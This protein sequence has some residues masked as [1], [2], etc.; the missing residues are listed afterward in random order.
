MLKEE[1]LQEARRR[2][3]EMFGDRLKPCLATQ[4]ENLHH[5]F[6]TGVKPSIRAY[7]VGVLEKCLP[8]L[9]VGPR[10]AVAVAGC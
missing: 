5:G 8:T 9:P 3:E 1:D 10:G 6:R 4:G 2:L 7:P